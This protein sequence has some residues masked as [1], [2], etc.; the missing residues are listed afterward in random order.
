M[1]INDYVEPMHPVRKDALAPLERHLWRFRIVAQEAGVLMCGYRRTPNVNA[2]INDD[3]MFSLSNHGLLLVCKFL[4]IWDSFGST[5]KVEPRV[6]EVRRAAQPIVDRMRIWTGLDVFRDSVLAH[7]YETTDKKLISPRYIISKLDVPSA[8]AEVILL[9]DLVVY[10]T[11]VV[12]SAF[13]PV[14]LPLRSL[15]ADLPDEVHQNKG[16]QSGTELDAAAR[17]VFIKVDQLLAAIEVDTHGEA[18]TELIRV[19]GHKPK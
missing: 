8:L 12:L 2:M 6:V 18:G 4:E 10:A 7:T 11:I 3:L 5:A 15:F 16:I 17:E 1:R 9:V 13:E 14:Y 19:A